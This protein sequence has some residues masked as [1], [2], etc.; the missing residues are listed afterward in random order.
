MAHIPTSRKVKVTANRIQNLDEF[1]N[2]KEVELPKEIRKKFERLLF[3]SSEKISE[4]KIKSLN[5]TGYDLTDA[6]NDVLR[7]L[8]NPRVIEKLNHVLDWMRVDTTA[9]DSIK[10]V[11]DL[12]KAN[13]L[14]D[15]YFKSKSKKV[16]DDDGETKLIK[17]LK[18]GYMIV[19]CLDKQAFDRE[20]KLMGHCV[21]S[22]WKEMEQGKG[23]RIL[24]LR[25]SKNLPHATMEIRKEK[26][27]S[28]CV[29]L[30]GKQNA[31]VVEKYIP[32]ILDFF[33][34]VV[35]S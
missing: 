13:D 28:M 25:D 31:D 6:E 14:A 33:D 16:D 21:G 11:A 9:W 15:K 18:D 22:Y 17:A 10:G 1:F 12:E 29:Q 23:L 3:E 30:Q 35:E 19:E 20:G 27:K 2:Q 7:S 34:I 5:L 24:S 32:Y 26:G 4:R 8:E